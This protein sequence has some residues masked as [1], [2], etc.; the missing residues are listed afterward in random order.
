VA[1]SAA[2]ILLLTDV[3]EKRHKQMTREAFFLSRPEY[4]QNYNQ[5][6]INRK[7]DQAAKTRKFLKQYRGKKGYDHDNGGLMEDADE[8]SVAE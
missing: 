2:Q 5:P 4:H 8:E 7:V 3:K 6:Y 1:G